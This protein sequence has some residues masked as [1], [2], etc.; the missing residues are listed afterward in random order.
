MYNGT[1]VLTGFR[2]PKL[3]ILDLN[4]L[5]NHLGYRPTVKC[6]ENLIFVGTKMEYLSNDVDTV[7]HSYTSMLN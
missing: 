3:I 7:N 2:I 4:L 1:L 5:D 6:E